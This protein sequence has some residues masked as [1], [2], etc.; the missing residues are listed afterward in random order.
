LNLHY[1]NWAIPTNSD[2]ASPVKLWRVEPEK[3]A[4]QLTVLDKETESMTLGQ[5]LA[6]PLA[7]QRKTG[8]SEKVAN[9]LI[10]LAF[11]AQAKCHD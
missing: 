11:G 5:T 7:Q 4:I 1:A 6:Q 2:G 3:I 8:T 10:Y 9:Q